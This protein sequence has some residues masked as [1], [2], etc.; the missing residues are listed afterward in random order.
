MHENDY[1]QYSIIIPDSMVKKFCFE[2]KALAFIV[3]T[4]VGKQYSIILNI[5]PIK[6][7]F[8]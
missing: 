2:M 3:A 6:K 5:I 7:L 1:N 8:L 4:I